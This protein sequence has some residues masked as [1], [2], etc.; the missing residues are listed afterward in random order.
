M[1]IL[2]IAIKVKHTLQYGQRIE[3][4]TCCLISFVDTKLY[5]PDI[6]VT[7]NYVV[8]VLYSRR[9]GEDKLHKITLLCSWLYTNA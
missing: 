1:L 6:Y 7:S 9:Y 2:L 8:N 3:S 4:L 5:K